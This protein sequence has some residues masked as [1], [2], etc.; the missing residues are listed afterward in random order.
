MAIR[1]D[2]S[3][4][5]KDRNAEL[6]NKR[7]AKVKVFGAKKLNASYNT[8]GAVISIMDHPQISVTPRAGMLVITVFV[9]P[10]LWSA[11]L[12]K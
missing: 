11:L 9:Q 2:P 3:F 1:M 12:L 6:I 4:R 7:V 5:V 10:T 8:S